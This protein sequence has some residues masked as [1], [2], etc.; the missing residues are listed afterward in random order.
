MDTECEYGQRPRSCARILR[1][2]TVFLAA[3]L[4]VAVTALTLPS[5]DAVQASIRL[6]PLRTSHLPGDLFGLGLA[7]SRSTA[8]VGAPGRHGQVGAAY[9]FARTNGAWRQQAVLANPSRV[10]DLFAL[11][12]AVSS[13]T[14]GT[15]AVIGGPGAN[16]AAGVAYVFARS[17]TT[18]H[19]QAQ[20]PDPAGT[21]DDEFGASVA[22]SGTT[23]LIGAPFARN[24]TGAAYVF[25][26]SGR[27]WH[28]QAKLASSLGG[29]GQGF[30]SSV[31]IDRGVAV[32]GA[33]NA[34]NKSGLAFI[35]AR[36]GTHW[37][38]QKVLNNP[39]GTGTHGFGAAVSVSG[40]TAVI[41]AN[42]ASIR[43]GTAYVF[44][45]SGAKWTRRAQLADPAAPA[46][47]S[48]GSAVAISGDQVLIGAPRNGLGECGI[49]YEFARTPDG[50]R[51][52]RRIV[53]PG[54]PAVD[55]FGG[56]V[57]LSGANALIS[58]PYSNKAAGAAYA[59]VVP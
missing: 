45:R 44:A 48:Y 32:I 55:F 33:V 52:Q 4:I 46:A 49:A 7:V 19:L 59:A 20:I 9:V 51:E 53:S 56:W 31:A 12:V 35:Y 15:F 8:I 1:T 29:P 10:V 34:Y 36:T 22:L 2:G 16:N 13:T 25:V 23:A 11:T 5:A 18:W 27:T 21:V 40:T 30:G 24:N 38:V 50:W 28:L 14:A 3:A 47:D 39:A 57:A 17:G 54:C 6:T 42:N 37:A 26:L 41:G 58:A 43:T